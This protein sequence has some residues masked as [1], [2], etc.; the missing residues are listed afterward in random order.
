MQTHDSLQR[1][2]PHNC[3]L[4]WT[5]RVHSLPS[6]RHLLKICI[7]VVPATSRFSTLLFPSGSAT[8]PSNCPRIGSIRTAR[9][10]HHFLL[11]LPNLIRGRQEALKKQL[12]LTVC[13]FL[14]PSVTFCHPPSL[15]VTVC[16]LSLRTKYSPQPFLSHTPTLDVLP[17]RYRGY[18]THRSEIMVFTSLDGVGKRF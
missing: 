12:S 5:K 13:H 3:F 1:S 9:L 14:S 2:T 17:L 8:I 15:P 11:V 18:F 10:A 6:Y 16:L 4:F 7:A